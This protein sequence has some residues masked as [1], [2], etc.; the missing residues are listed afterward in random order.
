MWARSLRS[1]HS[2]EKFLNANSALFTSPSHFLTSAAALAFGNAQLTKL[3]VLLRR[4]AP[5][6]AQIPIFGK[7]VQPL[8]F[9]GEV[10]EYRF[11]RISS[12]IQGRERV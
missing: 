11:L 3:V 6:L 4:G 10:V 12:M 5:A 2:F 9:L 1:L 7:V 8:Q